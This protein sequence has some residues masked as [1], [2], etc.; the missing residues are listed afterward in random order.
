M[1]LII[2]AFGIFVGNT[3]NDEPSW[4][5]RDGCKVQTVKAANGPYTYDSYE[6]CKS[7]PRVYQGREWKPTQSRSREA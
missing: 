3:L 4:S 5:M 1:E 7:L 6:H 2:L